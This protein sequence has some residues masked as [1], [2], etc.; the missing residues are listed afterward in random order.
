[1]ILGVLNSSNWAA[2]LGTVQEPLNPPL[3]IIAQKTDCSAFLVL[4]K[5]PISGLDPFESYDGYD[6]TYCQEWGLTVDDDVVK[7]VVRDL[8]AKAYPPK[9]DY[10]DAVVK[11]DQPAIDAYRAACLAVKLRYPK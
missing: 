6:F 2:V 10:L 11:G 9:E 5:E 1:M 3:N 7:R 4:T 8:R